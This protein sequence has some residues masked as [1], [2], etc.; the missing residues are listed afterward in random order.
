MLD[1]TFGDADAI[2]MPVMRIRT[3]TVAV[4]EPGS[5]EFSARVLYQMSALTRW[6]NGLGLPAI[7]IP[8]GFDRDGLPVAVQFIGRP[9]GD[10]AL[11]ELAAAIQLHTDWHGRVPTAAAAFSGEFA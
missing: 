3:P 11:L 9:G 4:C 6:V 2:L 10:R 8:A 5:P 7:A 1:A